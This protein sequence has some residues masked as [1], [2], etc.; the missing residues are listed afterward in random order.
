VRSPIGLV[1]I[2]TQS[3]RMQ[4]GDKPPLDV[5]YGHPDR[6]TIRCR[7]SITGWRRRTC[8]ISVELILEWLA[9]GAT[10]QDIVSQ[11]S[12]L[13]IAD[14]QQSL[15]YAAASIHDSES[16]FVRL[17]EYCQRSCERS[18]PNDRCHPFS[19]IALLTKRLAKPVLIPRHELS[20]N[21][22]N[23]R[24]YREAIKDSSPG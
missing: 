1:V 5:P 4:P 6:R 3:P 15:R 8:E 20:A 9:S 22:T 24:Q 17:R 2:S 13:E 16:R 19:E 21:D 23:G 10:P 11:Y 12:H 7:P 14:V 18:V